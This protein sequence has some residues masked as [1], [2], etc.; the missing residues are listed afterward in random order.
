MPLKICRDTFPFQH[1][2]DLLPRLWT[3]GGYLTD[4]LDSMP[5]PV[6]ASHCDATATQ[7]C[8]IARPCP[9]KPPRGFAFP[10]LL[11]ALLFQNIA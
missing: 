5:L 10:L 4:R 1:F 3:A 8:S 9:S 2:A 6:I 7:S 11:S